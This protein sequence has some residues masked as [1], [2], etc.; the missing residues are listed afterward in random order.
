MEDANILRSNLLRGRADG[1]NRGSDSFQI[2]KKSVKGTSRKSCPLY[3]DAGR[4]STQYLSECKYLPE[5]D[6]RYLTR[7]CQ[8]SNT[9]PSDDSSCSSDSESLVAQDIVYE[10]S[11][12]VNVEQSPFVDLFSGCHP[13]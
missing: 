4:S 7:A 8:V 12:R 9:S 13:V 2:K 11:R 10:S 5:R 3:K 6:R 1:F